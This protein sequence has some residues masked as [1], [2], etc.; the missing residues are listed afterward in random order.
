MD[1][2]RLLPHPTA[3]NTPVR[4]LTVGVRR[5]SELDLSFRLDGAIGSLRVPPRLAT[6]GR[7]DGLWEHTCFEVFLRC[8]GS[9]AY[10]EL[11]FSPSGEWTRYEFSSYRE[12]A[13]PAGPAP[14]PAAPSMRWTASADLLALDASIALAGTAAARAPLRL[15]LAAVVEARDGSR[16]YWAVRHP[17]GRPDFHHAD[18]FAIALDP[19]PG[20]SITG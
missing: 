5:S 20:A 9:P 2:V 18:G 19:P 12:R 11:N 16:S 10:S 13:A 17:S 14:E 6:P 4:S 8:D 15:A 1:R 3:G 7:A